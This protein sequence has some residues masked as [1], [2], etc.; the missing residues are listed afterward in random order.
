[1][2]SIYKCRIQQIVALSFCPS[3]K[4]S[5][6]QTLRLLVSLCAQTES[7]IKIK[8]FLKMHVTQVQPVTC[9]LLVQSLKTAPVATEYIRIN[10]VT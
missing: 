3:G 6:L 9:F 10:E 5:F 4:H 8:D 1:M 2:N 7:V